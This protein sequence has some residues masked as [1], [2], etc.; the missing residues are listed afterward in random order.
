M[1][2]DETNWTPTN[3]EAWKRMADDELIKLFSILKRKKIDWSHELDADTWAAIDAA[4]VGRLKSLRS[5]GKCPEALTY[6]GWSI[7]RFK[8]QRE[9]Q[10]GLGGEPGKAGDDV[11]VIY[12]RIMDDLGLSMLFKA[13]R[14]GESPYPYLEQ[15]LKWVGEM[16]DR[17]GVGARATFRERATIYYRELKRRKLID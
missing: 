10:P 3:H 4:I 16:N 1:T 15:P 8:K 7:E 6:L 13:A 14:K 17:L 12:D 2:S 11:D 5:K 9:A